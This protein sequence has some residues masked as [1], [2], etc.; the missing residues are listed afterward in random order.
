MKDQECGCRGAGSQQGV[1]SITQ[2]AEGTYYVR[3]PDDVI[4]AKKESPPFQNAKG[5]AGLIGLL[6]LEVGGVVGST[7]SWMPPY[8]NC[9][10][11]V[12][13]YSVGSIDD[14]GSSGGE[15]DK[16]VKERDQTILFGWMEC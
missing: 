2:A 7:V 16:R 1:I 6:L 11:F 14:A 5:G 4:R 8:A 9:K 3:F 10:K 15:Q 13:K 12:W